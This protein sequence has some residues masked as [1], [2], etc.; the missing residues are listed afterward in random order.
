[1]ADP[2]VQKEPDNTAGAGTPASGAAASAKNSAPL[3]TAEVQFNDNI[4]IHPG[5]H[6]SQYDKGPVQAFGARGQG[7]APANLLAMICEDHLT[8]R[9]LK[10]GNY[11]AIINP[12]LVRLIASG[13]VMWPAAGR[14]KYCF[15]YENTL[16]DPIM[17]DDIRGGLG[18]RYDHVLSSVIRPIAT[19][20]A[21]F[22]DKDLVHG[23]I[24]PSN[25]FNGGKVALERAV[26]GECLSLPGSY[27]QPVLYETVDRALISPIGRGIGLLQNDLYALGVSLAIMLRH[28]DPMEGLSDDEIIEKKIEE[29]SFNCLL[30]KDRL[31][32][33]AL[34]LLRGL[35]QDDEA[36]RWTI[37][38][39]LQWIDGRRLSGKQAGRHLKASRPIVFNNEKYIRPELLA[40]DLPKNVNEARILI[41][42]GE[43]EQWLSRALEDKMATARLET[44]INQAAEG[45]KGTGYVER[46]LTRVSMALHPEGPMRYKNISVTPEG[47]GVALTEA[48][49]LKRD[50]QTYVDFFMNYFI[51][52]WVDMQ[53]THVP[54]VSALISRFDGARA[55]LRLKTMGGGIEK[56][57]YFLNQEAPCFS[58]KLQ[59]YAVRSPE[60]LLHAY[61]KISK[62]QSRPALFF[63]RHVVA[64]LSV[65]DRKTIDPYLHDLNASEAYRRI[66]AEMKTLASI[67]KRSQMERFPGLSAWFVSNLEPVYERFHDKDLRA[68]LK[69]KAERLKDSGDLVKIVMLF[70]DPAVYSEDNMNFRRA[71]R[72]YHDL[73][74]ESM[75]LNRQLQNQETFG[76]D[77]GKQAAAAVSGVL[78][79]I[80]ILVMVFMSF[81][82]TKPF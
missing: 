69:K 63:D 17:K 43:L 6:L 31:S 57:L 5:N 8:P 30:G 9:V 26:L 72:Q 51:T 61:E 3:S 28:M 24:R 75:T 52:Q 71:M 12:S 29:G 4:V 22:R 35:L 47:V 14:Q 82:N 49:V 55:F 45:G 19:V 21:D 80:I 36:Q 68:D 79:A 62:Q 25:I 38:D 58:E 65:K 67:Q 77:A 54:D 76:L 59:K 33:A 53:D 20:L 13:P 70:D 46:L 34:E 64:F 78:A 1:M 37:D 56:C 81:G 32:G 11:A 60:E 50:I 15:I 66:L 10:A 42:G 18:M 23:N 41:E 39:F 74:Q 27:N 73:E 7:E 40:R 44:A 48:F 16:G 2:A